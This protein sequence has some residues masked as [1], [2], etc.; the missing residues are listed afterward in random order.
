MKGGRLLNFIRIYSSTLRCELELSMVEVQ[1][2]QQLSIATVRAIHERKRL[3]YLYNNQN[4][5][6]FKC[7]LNLKRLLI[8]WDII[9]SIYQFAIRVILCIIVNI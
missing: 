6:L 5:S 4:G 8:M 1:Q 2:G 9:V 7:D 3:L